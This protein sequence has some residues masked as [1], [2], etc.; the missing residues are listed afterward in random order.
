MRANPRRGQNA[1]IQGRSGRSPRDQRAAKYPPI[2]WNGKSMRTATARSSL[3]RPFSTILRL[4]AASCAAH[5][6]LANR[7]ITRAHWTSRKGQK[8][9]RVEGTGGLTLELQ[10]T[11]NCFVDTRDAR[12]LVPKNFLSLMGGLVNCMDMDEVNPHL[13]LE[14]REP[15]SDAKADRTPETKIS[16]KG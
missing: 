6:I 7:C 3:P 16:T 9:A 15:K 11:P 10:D 4:V 12:V 5:P 2:I 13:L 14:E 8:Q 1:H